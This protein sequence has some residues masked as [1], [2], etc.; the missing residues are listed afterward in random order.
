M[1]SF[2]GLK[3][4]GDKKKKS[5][6]SN[7]PDSST[8]SL[9]RLD[10]GKSDAA[11]TFGSPNGASTW[12]GT[13]VRKRLSS[14]ARPGT[15]HSFRSFTTPRPVFMN[16]T[17]TAS[18]VDLQ[19]F[20]RIPRPNRDSIRH[21]SET[22]ARPGFASPDRFSMKPRAAVGA[23][24]ISS[25]PSS[26]RPTMRPS[27]SSGAH[28][29]PLRRPSFSSFGREQ[30][31]FVTPR[32][33]SLTNQRSETGDIASPENRRP[34]NA[35]EKPSLSESPVKYEALDS[36]FSGDEG[37]DE[38]LDNAPKPPPMATSIS[39]NTAIPS[40][41]E[42]SLASPMH[43]SPV[44]QSL[45]SPA[46]S[47]MSASSSRTHGPNQMISTS[48]LMHSNKGPPPG[49][50]KPY[51]PAVALNG[52]NPT[53]RMRSPSDSSSQ[54]ASSSVPTLNESLSIQ[55]PTLDT[56][57]ISTSG[58]PVISES[59]FSQFNFEFDLGPSSS[60]SSPSKSA[61]STPATEVMSIMDRQD[62]FSRA[63]TTSPSPSLTL[64]SSHESVL[65]SRP[66][67]SKSTSIRSTPSPSQSVR[68]ARS[69]ERP[70]FEKSVSTKPVAPSGLRVVRN[71]IPSI[72]PDTS[73]LGIAADRSSFVAKLQRTNFGARSPT[74]ESDFVLHGDEALALQWEG[75][76]VIRD[77]AAKRDTFTM[78]SPRRQS[79]SFNLDSSDHNQ[80]LFAGEP[81]RQMSLERPK[82]SAGP[83]TDFSSGLD[84]SPTQ[85]ARRASGGASSNS[86][87]D[88]IRPSPLKIRTTTAKTVQAMPKSHLSVAP[89]QATLQT[90]VVPAQIAQVAEVGMFEAQSAE[91]SVASHLKT[92]SPKTSLQISTTTGI[93]T[94]QASITS[95][96]TEGSLTA[97]SAIASP[98]LESPASVGAVANQ[99]W[100][101]RVPY[102]SVR[103]KNGYAVP[104][105]RGAPTAKSPA[106]QTSVLPLTSLSHGHSSPPPPA[107]HPARGNVN[108]DV[109]RASVRHAPSHPQ[110][111]K[112]VMPQ[113]KF[114]SPRPAVQP[115]VS[116]VTQNTKVI[117]P[118]GVE[119]PSPNSSSPGT[120][121]KNTGE[122]SHKRENKAQESVR[123]RV[124]N[125]EV[126]DRNRDR[127][128]S[129]QAGYSSNGSRSPISGPGM[130]R[131]TSLLRNRPP[132][133]PVRD[134]SVGAVPVSVTGDGFI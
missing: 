1:V 50:F 113:D 4:G 47:Y 44:V 112:L 97:D 14:S 5:Q 15:S 82:T 127:S 120:L 34:S 126:Q 88:A 32:E 36:L 74:P 8:K 116:A 92:T 46:H 89:Q 3:L 102:D 23:V 21:T 22:E 58:S 12:D 86:R 134:D 69:I 87:L 6:P 45:D 121:D 94:D 65:S 95:P 119:T 9:R 81:Q 26:S 83:A 131:D 51:S 7:S 24:G 110:R 73:G 106:Y 2:F 90:H 18:L 10:Q 68:S 118:L 103:D 54:L 78:S 56:L 30:L 31:L 70:S 132:P 20:D 125:L 93:A 123:D 115:P 52:G 67:V 107:R 91:V 109:P 41:S 99:L 84:G 129:P 25:S 42:M 28:H 64:I 80:G 79:F 128:R 43:S 63:S 29:E 72:V 33:S 100:P 77:V 105:P 13:P 66:S 37:V 122:A 48:P 71:A 108:A 62:S 17:A 96:A 130:R 85:R 59:P 60:L 98:A 35:T 53:D 55:P 75:P 38:V 57:T 27:T 49:A 111:P 101:A 61:V 16:G 133:R 117:W 104:N 114:M 40:Q 124:R 39:V 76:P 11:K 19:S